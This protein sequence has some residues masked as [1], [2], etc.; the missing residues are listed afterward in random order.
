M[1]IRI[2][3][4]VFAPTLWAVLFTGAAL[5]AFVSL[6]YWQLGRASEK[7]A[8]IDAFIAGNLT[9]VDATGLGF[10]ELARYQH[11]RLRGS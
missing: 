8:L 2:G 3:K 11:V 7:Q 9:S 6:G 4:R 1:S 10:D 5:A